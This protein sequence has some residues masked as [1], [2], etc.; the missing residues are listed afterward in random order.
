[1]RYFLGCLRIWTHN[2]RIKRNEGVH[3]G[4]DTDGTALCLLN[5]SHWPPGLEDV[6]ILL[7]ATLSKLIC[8]MYIHEN[9]CWTNFA[10]LGVWTHDLLLCKGE[11]RKVR[12]LN[13]NLNRCVSLEV[14]ICY[15][16][17]E[18]KLFPKII[19]S[20]IFFAAKIDLASFC[21]T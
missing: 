6:T 12:L 4:L 11:G 19:S 5:G 18:E 17:M 7:I 9:L 13:S 14:F 10:G 15:R 1:M 20:T 8:S 3:K 2:H 16:P 21:K